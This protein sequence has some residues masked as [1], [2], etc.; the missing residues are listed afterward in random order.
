[1]AGISYHILQP[2]LDPSF[3]QWY[4]YFDPENEEFSSPAWARWM[5]RTATD[6]L[7]GLRHRFVAAR[8]E[9]TGQWVGGVWGCVSETVPELV[10]FGWFLVEEA[11]RGRG[12]GSAIVQRFIDAYEAEGAEMIMLPTQV[13][14]ERAHGMYLRRG[15]RDAIV[16]PEG[17][18]SCFMVRA[19]Q[20]HY[21]RFFHVPADAAVTLGPVEY[22]DYIALD[23]LLNRPQVAS[24]L[25]P[26]G[27]LGRRRFVSM[28]FDWGQG[29][30]FV[31]RL[32]ERPVGVGMVKA[33]REGIWVDVYSLSEAVMTSLLEASRR[34]EAGPLVARVCPD[35]AAKVRAFE[36]AGFAGLE[37]SMERHL[38]RELELQ[39]FRA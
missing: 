23:Y 2:P 36:A 22:R 15:W 25:Y 7:P 21:E 32:N 6:D 19:P 30:V 8:D 35:D 14:N 34:E 11:Y 38:D 5:P 18:Q 26:A 31:A 16:Q 28:L 10:H 20:G 33:G 24:R 37:L 39:T 17:M 3:R 27:L 1:M 9:D 29:E 12:I 13:K 4:P